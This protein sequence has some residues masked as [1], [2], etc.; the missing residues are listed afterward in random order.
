MPFHPAL[1]VNRPLT[2][3][4]KHPRCPTQSCQQAKLFFSPTRSANYTLLPGSTNLQGLVQHESRV[5]LPFNLVQFA[6]Q[7]LLPDPVY[8]IAPAQHLDSVKLPGQP[9]FGIPANFAYQA[10]P[11][12]NPAQTE[13]PAQLE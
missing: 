4:Q 5:E 12:A 7:L 2:P 8:L 9:I 13:N 10:Q 6:N 11:S 3:I 1:F